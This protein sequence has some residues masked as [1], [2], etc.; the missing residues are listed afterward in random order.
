MYAVVK[1]Q[2]YGQINTFSKYLPFFYLNT[3]FADI[4]LE[5]NSLVILL[6]KII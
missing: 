2:D 1:N 6:V 4:L 3:S 5:I